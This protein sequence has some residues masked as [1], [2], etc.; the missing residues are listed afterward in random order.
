MVISHRKYPQTF[1]NENSHLEALS[2]DISPQ[3]VQPLGSAGPL[4]NASDEFYTP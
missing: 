2:G 1:P 3:I 4:E